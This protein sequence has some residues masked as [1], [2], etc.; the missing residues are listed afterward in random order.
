MSPLYPSIIAS[1]FLGSAAVLRV[2]P[3]AFALFVFPLLLSGQTQAINGSIR[4]RI[5]DQQDAPI[6]SSEVKAENT[7]TGFSRTATTSED[8]YYLLPNLPLGTYTVTAIKSGFEI[9]QRTGVVLNAGAEAIVDTQLRVGS[10]STSI[11][12]SGGAPILETSRIN[13]GRTITHEETDN[14]P[15]TSRNPYNFILFQPG[16]SGHPNAELGIPRTLNTNGLLDRINYQFDG[17]VDTQS[18]RYGLRLF[19]IANIYVQEIQ[20]VANSFAPEFGLT[21][22]NIY[23]VISG[24]GSNNLH[25]EFYYIGRPTDASARPILLGTRPKPDLTL[26]DI[27]VNASG[28]IIKDKLFIF[29]AY[30]HLTRGLPQPN[31]ISSTAASQLGISNLLG[32]APSIQHAHF[33][34]LR[35]DWQIAA[36]HQFFA[37][38]NYFRNDYPF[39]TNVGGIYALDAASDFQDRAYIAGGQLLSTFSPNALNE[40]RFSWPYRKNG[41]VP[42]SLNGPGPVISIPGVATFNGTNAAGNFFAEKIPSLNDNFTLIRG[43]HSVKIGGGFQQILDVQLNPTFNQYTFPSINAYLQARAGTAPLGYTNYQ[44]AVGT[45]GAGYHSLFWNAFA[46]DTWQVRSNLVLTFGVRY[47]RFQPP[48]APATQPFVYSRN[49]RTPGANWAPRFGLAWNIS[50]KTLL[51]ASSGLFYEAPATNIFYNTLFNNG[52]S[53]GFLATILPAAAGAPLFPQVVNLNSTGIARIP[54]IT[55]L[56]PNYKNAYTFTSSFQLESQLTNNDSL[57]L[58]FVNTGARNQV[59]Y[60]NL[61]LANITGRLADGRPIFGSQ[62]IYPQFG[63]I[64]LQDIGAITSYNALLAHYRHRLAQGF[65][66]DASYTWSHTISDSPDTNS[67]EQNQFIQDS[68]NRTRD[69]G[70][71]YVNRPH[72]FTLSAYI[73]PRI[74]PGG[75]WRYLANNNELTILANVSS[76]DAQNIIANRSLTNDGLVT[77]AVTRPLF[78]G[79]YTERGPKIV[80]FDARYTRTLFTL[81]DRIKPK[82]LA[83]A[84]NLLNHPNI[85]ALNTTATVNASGA[86]TTPASLAPLSTTLE[87]RIIQ[88]GIRCDW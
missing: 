24:S 32:T 41:N 1:M 79:R 42:N 48:D 25:G 68:T 43:R 62:R 78:I 55:T 50:P 11:E 13:I 38:V 56:T 52:S 23:N 18:D 67:F 33:A 64:T 81:F 15:L 51:R 17:M 72:A 7:S 88:L 16:V 80:Q 63:N 69:R 28:P 4:G 73:A 53:S 26:N 57:M 37:R 6:S 20:T 65:Q 61:N 39:N 66:V 58:G 82:F 12:V 5:V 54:D 77:P 87:G 49:F 46:Q 29:G 30:E 3:F 31:T 44:A 71:S 60:R 14:L 85:T 84:N 9:T 2:L 75:F 8:G 86:I 35:A 76:G 19:P 21:S 45:L 59:F 47:D 83:E 10:A 70:N 27:A 36:K 74:A 40:L 34:D 22:G